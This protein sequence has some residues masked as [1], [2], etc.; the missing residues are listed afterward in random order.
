MR[1]PRDLYGRDVAQALCSRWGYVKVNQVGSHII[2]Q[3]EVPKHHRISIPDHKPLRAG[4]SVIDVQ[5]GMFGA[6]GVI[7][8]LYQREATGRGQYVAASLYESTVFLVGQ[9]MA[10]FAVTGKPAAPMPVRVSAGSMPK[11][12]CWQLSWS[13]KA[14]GME[15]PVMSASRMAVR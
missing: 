15:G 7:A 2:L 1:L 14:W 10:Q 13:P 12:P 4:T 6:L 9:H 3:T 8:A 11:G 5:G